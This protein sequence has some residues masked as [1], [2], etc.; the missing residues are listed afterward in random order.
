MSNNKRY[1]RH[2]RS[3]QPRVRR[4]SVYV[5]KPNLYARIAAVFVFFVGMAC[6]TTASVYA[7]LPGQIPDNPFIAF[8][9]HESHDSDIADD[10]Q[11]KTKG[12]TLGD[13]SVAAAFAEVNQNPD[14]S[15]WSTGLA[16]A[17]G[18]DSNDE[19]AL[20][21]SGVPLDDYSYTVAVPQEKSYLLGQ[22]VEIG[23]GDASL[24]ASIT[25][26]GG[27]GPLGRDFDLAPGVWRAFGANSESDWG[28]RT[29]YYHFVD[30]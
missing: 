19:G 29:I 9:K 13:Q 20:T 3:R 18:L 12:D 25:D 7:F 5:R 4:G 1:Q 16:S 30:E 24:V 6:L 27:F 15:G 28:L 26:T 23:Y 22:S 2:K 14:F 21:A 8:E 10:A 17:Y 11:E